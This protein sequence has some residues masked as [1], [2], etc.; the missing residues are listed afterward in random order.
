MNLKDLEAY[1]QKYLLAVYPRQPVVF[2][3]GKGVYLFDQQG[4]K[5]LDFLSGLSVCSLGHCHPK[6]VSAIRN[7]ARKLIHTTNLYYT[8]PA[9]KL[10]KFLSE[11]TGGMK[12]FFCNSGAEANEGA[13]KLARRWGSAIGKYEIITA[14]GSFHGRTL[15]TLAATGQEKFRKGFGPLPEGFLHV[16]F[17]NLNALEKAISPRTCAVMLETIQGESGVNVGQ[18][19]YIKGVRKLCDEKN[20]L[21]ILDEVQTGLCRTGYFFDYM[22][23]GIKPDI[24]TLAK[25]LANG[26]PM[27][28]FLCKPEMASVFS[29]GDHGSTFGATPLACAASLAVLKELKRHFLDKHARD[30]G[31]YF[32]NKLNALAGKH[33][34]I[35]EVRGRGLMTGIELKKPV[36]KDIVLECLT[37]GL[38][39]NAPAPGVIRALP[40]LIVKEKHINRAVY[41]LDKI[42]T[43]GEG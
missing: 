29:V 20:I 3:K 14:E 25:S 26:I 38:I 10:A 41:I 17:N 7:Q 40:P 16:P 8:L 2:T 28:A 19:A 42:L 21:L 11:L 27:G 35:Q 18:D 30:M 5:Y 22:H 24:L 4:R 23:Y 1:E 43:N 34:V 12:C 31:Q 15:A 32:F 6:V 13:I 37:H 39:L 36:A 9:F 33:P